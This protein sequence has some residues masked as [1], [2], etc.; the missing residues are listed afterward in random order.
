[1]KVESAITGIPF[2]E[3]EHND[4]L[5]LSSWMEFFGF[6]YYIV[7]GMFVFAAFFV[8][9]IGFL[10]ASSHMFMLLGV[11][12]LLAIFCICSIMLGMNLFKSSEKFRQ[13]A[14]TDDADQHYLIEGFEKMIRFFWFY[15]VLIIL[16]LVW[17]IFI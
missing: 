9:V 2:S 16:N 3:Q 5:S 11:C 8:G 6:F 13:V 15:G 4:L 1:M 17:L 14:E 10:S 12:V 7:S